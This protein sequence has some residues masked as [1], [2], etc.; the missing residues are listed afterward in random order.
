MN[1]NRHTSVRSAFGA[2]W[3]LALGSVGVAGNRYTGIGPAP[4]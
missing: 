1:P 3:S 2:V 4:I